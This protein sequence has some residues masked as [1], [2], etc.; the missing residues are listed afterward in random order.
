V[1]IAGRDRL[2]PTT[3]VGNYPN[4]TWYAD[5]PWAVFPDAAGA[6]PLRAR[7]GLPAAPEFDSPSR[8]AFYDAVAA[9]VH[10]QEEAGLDV[11]ADGRVY[12][13]SSAYGQILYHY[14][15]RLS[16][17]EL[18][19]GTDFVS[20]RC[21][22]PVSL[23][24]PLH[25][26]TLSAV[27]RATDRPVKVSY[28][29]L[30]V[31]TLFAKDEHYGAQR[32]LGAALADALNEDFRRL[33]DAGV[34]VIQIDEFLWSHGVSGWEIELLNRAVA[35]VNVQFWVHVCRSASARPRPLL[36]SGG[37]HG[38]KRYVLGDDP[39]ATEDEP[40]TLAALWPT[41][42]DADVQVLNTEAL[43]DADLAALRESP[44]P[45]EVVAGVIDVRTE[46]VE[47]ASEVAARIRAVLEA[48]PATRLGLTTSCGLVKLNRDVA[49]AK[50]AALV[51][52]A[53]LVRAE[54][55]DSA[56]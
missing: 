33:A 5:Q 10:D 2:L 21:T 1:K 12:G 41:V 36:V 26:E 8:E 9:I 44:W 48:V 51:A 6:L 31:L 19:A 40:K 34:D 23:R 14:Y 28:T 11:I 15:E 35:G 22:G 25:T 18:P 53:A 46:Q 20:P 42:L 4:P 50:L 3:M 56:A 27:R 37:R 38:F 17:F 16:G 39:S 45:G 7:P 32:E 24:V 54:I 52:G 49:R 13:G 55:K 47:T 29:G 43:D 30:Q